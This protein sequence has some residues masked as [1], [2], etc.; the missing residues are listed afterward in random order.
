[1][2]FDERRLLIPQYLS[3]DLTRQEREAFEAELASNSVLR[4]ELEEFRMLWDDLGHIPQ[5][6]PSPALRARFYQKLNKV[7]RSGFAASD[8][9][10]GW[11]RPQVLSQ[12]AAGLALLIVGIVI[13]RVQGKVPDRD[14]DLAQ[15]KAQVQSLR[16]M[17]ALSLL[18]RQSAASRLEGVSWSSR[19]DRPD[20][21]IVSALIEALNH[22]PS[23]NVRLASIDAIQRFAS[24]GREADERYARKALVDALGEQ[25]SPLVQIALID[26]AVHV[27]DASAVPQLRKLVHNP[28]LNSA[29]RQRAQWGLSKL[30]HE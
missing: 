17:V 21:E 27:R 1:M 7:E 18:E 25:D 14:A 26:S 13:G 23:V 6:Q 16:Q 11:W 8:R 2:T 9:P 30:E 24:I 5:P 10:S 3:G 4:E 20:Q 19:I 29:V 12:I 15:L 22:D 28:D